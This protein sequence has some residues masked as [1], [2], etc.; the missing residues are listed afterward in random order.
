MADYRGIK[1]FTVQSLASDPSANTDTEGQVWYNTGSKTLKGI[2]GAQ[3]AAW[4]SG[5]A[6]NTARGYMSGFGILT[7]AVIAGGPGAQTETET[8]N[9]TAWSVSPGTLNQG[10]DANAACGTTTAGL[11]Y[12]GTPP[13][14]ANLTESF[15]GTAWTSVNNMTEA[16]NEA[17]AGFGTQTAA[18]GACG[19]YPPVTDAEEWDGTSWAETGATN[20]ARRDFAGAGIQTSGIIFGGIV[21]G[22]T[23]NAETY[24]GSTWTEVANL[25][26]ARRGVGRAGATDSAA[27]AIGGLSSG[28][29]EIWNGTSWTEVADLATNTGGHTGT[30]GTTTAAFCTGGGD[31]PNTTA[32]EEWHDPS[33]AVKTFTSS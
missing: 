29:C 6:L 11:F 10:R 26:T 12:G 9:G 17:F 20:T 16:H 28:V 5:G 27:L 2:I 25:N 32:T 1:G 4:S 8:Y 19:N 13:T 30:D 14:N 21:P 18:V 24:N 7:A 15:N 22:P 31:P 3:T 33:Q 23:A